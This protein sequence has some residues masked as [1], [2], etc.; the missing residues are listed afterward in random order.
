MQR[1]LDATAMGLSALCLAH[2]LLLPVAAAILPLLGVLADAE[3]VHWAMI[4]LAAPVAV[5]A[6]APVFKAR[7][8]PWAIP[9]LAVLGLSLLTVGVV[10]LFGEA[11]EVW[12]TTVGGVTLAS[13]HVLNWRRGGAHSHDQGVE[14]CGVRS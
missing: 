8:I 14:A 5:V 6:I 12:L 2:C 11:A 7:P 13:A 3:W 4:A 9:L 1:V 10:E